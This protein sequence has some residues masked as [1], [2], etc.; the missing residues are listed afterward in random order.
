MVVKF[1]NDTPLKQWWRKWQW[2]NA[3]FPQY[4]CL[5]YDLWPDY[6]DPIISEA[7]R[8]L[9]QE[10][11]QA[12]HHR[13]VRAQ[14]LDFNKEVL[15]KDQWTKYEDET[16]YLYPYI[17]QVEAE[18]YQRH[19]PFVKPGWIRDERQVD[20]KDCGLEKKP[21]QPFNEKTTWSAG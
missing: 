21:R 16:W 2:H 11:A 9:P 1:H 7:F 5:W 17:K 3:W 8:R 6:W 4:G 10:L 12:R 14:M 15:P 19:S 18:A 13:H 20:F